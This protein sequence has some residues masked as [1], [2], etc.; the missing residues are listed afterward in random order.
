M[1]GILV[2]MCLPPRYEYSGSEPSEEERPDNTE[3]HLLEF[4]VFPGCS[5]AIQCW[6]RKKEICLV[7][8]SCHFALDVIF[9]S[10]LIPRKMMTAECEVLP[11]V[12]C[13]KFDHSA[14]E[15]TELVSG[16]HRLF[17]CGWEFM[18][19]LRPG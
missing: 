14:S 4:F 13:G 6:M 9:L 15:G 8:L 11:L 16:R 1:Q 2:S 7:A 19:L 12:G 18:V 5:L 3:N 17:S 10:M